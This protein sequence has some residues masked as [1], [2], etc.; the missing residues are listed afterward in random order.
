MILDLKKKM[1]MLSV[2]PLM[3]LMSHMVYPILVLLVTV[4]LLLLDTGR[5][6]ETSVLVDKREILNQE[7][8]LAQVIYITYFL[9]HMFCFTWP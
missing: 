3:G 1:E 8:I 9:L 6:L 4:T 2:H 5:F 7:I